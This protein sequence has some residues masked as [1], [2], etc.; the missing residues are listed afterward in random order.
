VSQLW[1]RGL[2]PDRQSPMPLYYQLASAI[3]ERIRAGALC[4]G[5]Q[6]P[7]EREL[8]RE[9]GISR[10][11]AR[12]ALA[13][14]AQSGDVVVRHGVGTFVAAPK[15]THD[16]LHLLGFTE[17]ME[18]QA[19]AVSSRVLECAV[20][21]PPAAVAAAL[22][23]ADGAEAVHV[24]RLRSTQETPLLLETSYVPRAACPGLEDEDF[25]RQS[26]YSL[27]ELRYG[28]RLQSARQTIEAAPASAYESDLLG[29]AEGASTLVLEGVTTTD[30]GRPIEWFRA[31]YRAD[32][33]KFA[34]ESHRES[35]LLAETNAPLSVMLT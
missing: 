27:L 16:T 26:L 11:T 4:P 33:V 14:L 18:R 1:P 17:E 15:L 8:A 28:H 29:V 30:S 2:A 6:L 19:G 31:V 34:V 10:M 21:V 20:V 23:L 9:A 12:Q 24:V 32:R 25:G 35:R 22:A 5:D 7:A 3:R 13:D